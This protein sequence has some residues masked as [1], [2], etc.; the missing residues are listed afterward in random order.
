MGTQESAGLT[1]GRRI[2]KGIWML[3]N[4]KIWITAAVPVFVASI[5]AFCTKPETLTLTN[6]LWLLLGIFA[7]CLIELGKHGINEYVDFETGV[8]TS[9]APDDVTPVSGGRKTII[10]GMLKKKEVIVITVATLVP[11]VIIG[12]VICW[13]KSMWVLPIGFIGVVVAVMYT[14]P[15]FKLVYRGLGE[16]AVFIVYGPLMFMGPY[17]LITDSIE[18]LPFLISIPIGI[19]IA[20]ILVINEFPDYEADLGGG[21][22]NAVARLGKK[23]GSTLFGVMFIATYACFLIIALLFNRFYLLLPLLTIPMAYRAW[24]GS[25]LYANDTQ[26]LAKESMFR[27]IRLHGVVGLLLMGG[28]L[29]ETLVRYIVGLYF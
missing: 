7:L 23:K 6:I 22:M 10:S 20:N 27:T 26:T 21:K 4:P 12:L 19:I 25:K 13:F 5:F 11:A 8:D 17:A 3:G 29:V 15:P 28:I 1:K 24:K 9:V 14:L 16:L 2:A 18:V